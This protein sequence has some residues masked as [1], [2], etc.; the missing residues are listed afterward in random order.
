MP[1]HHSSHCNQCQSEPVAN[2]REVG[3]RG[4]VAR[5]VRGPGPSTKPVVP[6]SIGARLREA[7][8]EKALGSNQL[9]ELAGVGD[10]VVSRI[11]QGKLGKGP[12]GVLKK[13][14][15]ALAV[16]EDWLL[17]GTGEKYEHSSLLESPRIDER[18]VWPTIRAT[19]ISVAPDLEQYLATVAAY[20]VAHPIDADFAL[21]L[22]RHTQRLSTAT[23]QKKM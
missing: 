14:A 17:Y 21:M 13:L 19:V 8:E 6:G 18:P 22:A 11:E 1:R 20:R 12:G 2:G 4:A 7:R 9:C 3:E 15:K 23:D 16:R 10:G 5:R